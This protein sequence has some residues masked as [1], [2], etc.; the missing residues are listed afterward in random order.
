MFVSVGAL[1]S[2]AVQ[3]AVFFGVAVLV[4]IGVV[5]GAGFC[6]NWASTITSSSDRGF[7]GQWV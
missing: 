4:E 2:V 3:V 6:D 7:S 5:V 1:V